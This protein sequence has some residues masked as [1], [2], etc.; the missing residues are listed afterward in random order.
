MA[1]WVCY[2]IAIGKALIAAADEVDRWC[3][4]RCVIG[5]T[6]SLN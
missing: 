3:I 4:A 2:T 5:D 1:G 6:H